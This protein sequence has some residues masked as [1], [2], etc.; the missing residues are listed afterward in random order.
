MTAQIIPFPRARDPFDSAED[1]LAKLAALVHAR[2]V[3]NGR[4]STYEDCLRGC[5]R[6]AERILNTRS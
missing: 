4:K 2:A 1:E 5:E 6:A 3:R